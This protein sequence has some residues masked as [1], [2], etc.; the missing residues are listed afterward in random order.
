MTSGSGNLAQDG[1]L[2]AQIFGM[3][4]A[5]TLQGSRVALTEPEETDLYTPGM[6]DDTD[7]QVSE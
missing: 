4:K 5:C 7:W 6:C 2:I 3:P 1:R